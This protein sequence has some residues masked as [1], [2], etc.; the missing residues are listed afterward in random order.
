MPAVRSKPAK[1]APPAPSRQ[2]LLERE[3]RRRVAQADADPTTLVS[4][5]ES[6]AQCLKIISDAYVRYGA[7]S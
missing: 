6:Q 1:A 4:S 7:E 3:L 2:A 5:K